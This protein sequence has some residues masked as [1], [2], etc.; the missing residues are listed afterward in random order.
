MNNR[1]KNLDKEIDFFNKSW[2][3]INYPKL[4][5]ISLKLLIE[6]ASGEIKNVT[7]DSLE[8]DFSILRSINFSNKKIT[9]TFE[10]ILFTGNCNFIGDCDF[11]IHFN[12]CL[13]ASNTDIKVNFTSGVLFTKCTFKDQ[14][15]LHNSNFTSGVSVLGDA[16]FYLCT[17]HTGLKLTKCVYLNFG[18]FTCNHFHGYSFF[19]DVIFK[20]HLLFQSNTFHTSIEFRNLEHYSSLRFSDNIFTNEMLVTPFSPEFFSKLEILFF[21]QGKN[22]EAF[23]FYALE[24]RSKNLSQLNKSLKESKFLFVKLLIYVKYCFSLSTIYFLISNYGNSL[25]RPIFAFLI[26]TIFFAALFYLTLSVEFSP[27]GMQ[28]FWIPIKNNINGLRH[29]VLISLKGFI[30]PIY[31][32]EQIRPKNGIGVFFYIVNTSFQF[33]TF[34]LLAIAIRRLFKHSNI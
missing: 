16:G 25:I 23:Q 17:F 21:K 2:K 19:E 26:T 18:T 15:I 5:L 32:F 8:I 13:F 31:K 1:K 24:N 6:N 22:N 27:D 3:N 34:G 20:S 7:I 30:L 28:F 9:I 33:L 11:P 14:L 10:R 12:E 29:S 4:N